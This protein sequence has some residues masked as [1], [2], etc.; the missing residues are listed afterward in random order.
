MGMFVTTVPVS[1]DIKGEDNF[2]DFS[3]K[4]TGEMLSLMRHQS[5]PFDIL[6]EELRKKFSFEDVLYDI[7]LSYQNAKFLNKFDYK[8]RWHFC[9]YQSNSLTIHINDRENDGKLI[10]DYD[11]LTDLFYDKEMEFLHDH[12]ERILWHALDNPTKELKKLEMV[13]EAEKSKILYD[14]NNTKTDYPSDKTVQELIEKTVNRLPDKA[15]IIFE[16]KTITYSELN[17]RAN[18]VANRLREYGIGRNNIVG[19]MAKRSID[20][21]IGLFGIMKSGAAYL[22]IDPEYPQERIEYMLKDSNS[23]L[24]IT[25]ENLKDLVKADGIKKLFLEKDFIEGNENNPEVINSPS[26]LIYVIYT[27]GSTGKPKG[28]MLKHNNVNNLIKGACA[29]IDF[30]ENKVIVSVT[31]ICFDIFVAESWLA[32]QRGLTIIMANEQQQNISK[33]FDELCQEYHVNILNTTPSRTKLLIEKKEHLGYLKD[34][35]D[36]IVS[37]EGF[38]KDLLIKLQ[39]ISNAKIY[40][41]YGPTETTVWSTGKDLTDEEK[42]DIGIPVANT[43]IYILDKT[44]NI[45]SIGMTGDLYIGGDG[46]AAGYLGKEALTKAKFI[47]NP[48]REN[49][50]IYKTGDLARWMSNGEIVHMGRSDFQVKIRG[51]RIELED[52]KS[53]IL[54]NEAVKDAAIKVFNNKYIVAYLTSDEKL[55]FEIINK[56]LKNKLPYYM[57]PN[58]FIQLEVMPYTPNGKINI[59]LLPDCNFEEVSTIIVPPE[60]ETEKILVEEFKKVLNKDK[61]SI[62]DNFFDMGLDSLNFLTIQTVLFTYNLGIITQDF[63][64][65]PTIKEF[66]EHIDKKRAEINE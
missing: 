2:S 21:M 37:G 4:V 58:R 41:M 3:K 44:L 50:I 62:D 66:A 10:I 22:P 36:F 9:G 42:I 17:K 6:Q 59:N 13:S 55:D 8:S 38:P 27:S 33:L 61:I 16:G 49:D 39:N 12:I 26:D 56:D 57:M 51:Y 54:S 1:L 65:Y 28:V 25:Q 31:T 15:A 46:L 63:Y 64:E 5:Y 7:I 45:C 32:L 23:K 11:Y 19:L 18:I 14:F 52:I 35:T 48:Y 43:Q 30:N 40:N 34:I 53:N 20:M 60:T 29:Q 47:Q 24:L